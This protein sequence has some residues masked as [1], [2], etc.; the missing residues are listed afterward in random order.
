MAKKQFKSNF[1]D[2][3]SP[4]TG[5]GIRNQG[6]NDE[7]ANAEKE[8]EE[9][10]RTTLIL[11]RDTYETIKAIAY[12]ERV[13]IKDLV[14]RALCNLISTYGEEKLNEMKKIFIERDS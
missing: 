5:D 14:E 6:K 10:Q 12:W 8:S 13:Q 2:I 4:T 11:N 9:L 7:N 1:N 3:F